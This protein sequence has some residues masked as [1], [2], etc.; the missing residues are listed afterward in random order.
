VA[1]VDLEQARVL[2]GCPGGRDID[3]AL[4]ERDPVVGLSVYAA[5]GR[6]DRHLGEGVGHRVPLREFVRSTAHEFGRRPVSELLAGC[7][8]E[9][10]DSSQAD[11]AGDL[12]HRLGT[13]GAGGQLGPAGG[14]GG[15]VAAG[16]VT[17][18]DHALGIDVC[19]RGQVVDRCGRVLQRCR[20]AA[21]EAEPAVF[22]V[23]CHPAA[24]GEVSRDSVQVVGTEPRSPPPS[25]EERHDAGAALPRG[26]VEV[27]ELGRIRAVT[28]ALRTGFAH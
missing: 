23:P 25:V 26:Q 3:H 11:H 22:D 4:R 20:I 27:S 1:S 2:A 19:E 9:V 14:P 18:G 13:R 6:W 15:Q 10:E 21:A 5:Y 16:A 12:D 24:S 28:V 17:H 8:A 7:G